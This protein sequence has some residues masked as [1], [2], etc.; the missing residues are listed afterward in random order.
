MKSRAGYQQLTLRERTAHKMTL[1][2]SHVRQ[3]CL[4]WS[5]TVLLHNFARLPSRTI[6]DCAQSPIFPYVRSSSTPTL[7]GNHLGFKCTRSSLGINL[8]CRASAKRGEGDG[9]KKHFSTTLARFKRSDSEDGQSEQ[10]KQRGGRVGVR[11]FPLSRSSTKL[12]SRS[13]WLRAAFHYLNAWTTG[14]ALSVDLK[15]RWRKVTLNAWTQRSYG[16]IRDQEKEQSQY[17]SRK[18]RFLSFLFI[19]IICISAIDREIHDHI[20]IQSR[21]WWWN[22]LWIGCNSNRPWEKLWWLVACSV[23]LINQF[24]YVLLTLPKSC[25]ALFWTRLVL[26]MMVFPLQ[27]VFKGKIR[28]NK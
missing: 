20:S 14:P 19:L 27:I 5:C 22:E 18:T 1:Q 15:P 26:Y 3:V 11:S 17:K 21:T 13:L 8:A 2:I 7:T 9:E 4:K 12:L 25:L 28:K 16:K 24:L 10:I 23:S 6:I